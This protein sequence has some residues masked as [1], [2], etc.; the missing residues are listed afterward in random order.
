MASCLE[1]QSH[2]DIFTPTSLDQILYKHYRGTAQQSPTS[3]SISPGI[4]GTSHAYVCMDLR[5]HKV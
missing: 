4:S 1:K 3:S 5:P 2:V